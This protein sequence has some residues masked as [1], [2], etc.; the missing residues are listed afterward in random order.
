M[1]LVDSDY[2]G[3]LEGAMEVCYSR[4]GTGLEVGL[5]S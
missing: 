1:K 4:G 5:L 2:L 3:A